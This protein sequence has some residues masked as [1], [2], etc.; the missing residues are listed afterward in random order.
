MRRPS[1]T[2]HPTSD[3][4][5]EPDAGL[6]STEAPPN[7]GLASRY[8]SL[9]TEPRSRR[10]STA[11]SRLESRQHAGLTEKWG[12]VTHP[13]IVCLGGAGSRA[14]QIWDILGDVRRYLIAAGGYHRSDFVEVSYRVAPDGSPLPYQEEDSLMSLAQAEDNVRRTLDW[15]RRRS[16]GKLHLLG[17][18]LGGAVLF[19]AAAS[20]VTRDARWAGALGSIVTIASPVLGSDLD[21]IDL[22]G[23]LAAGPAGAEL[24]R[25]AADDVEKKRI[26]AAAARLRSLGVRLVTLAAEDDAVVTPEDALLP[27]DG[28]EPFAYI[29]RPRRRLGVSY[30]ETI[31]GHGA[32]PHDPMC[33]QRVFAALGPAEPASP[34]T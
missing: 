21:G 34:A 16:A 5:T 28:A 6:R 19:D 11:D 31:L 2:N 7:P 26:R 30:V 12:R 10:T 9:E 4:A 24:T 25:R 13:T 18:S 32:L 27:S 33:W 20:L 8:N 3:E 1:A 29:L 14:G 22:L 15:L 23:A 17:W